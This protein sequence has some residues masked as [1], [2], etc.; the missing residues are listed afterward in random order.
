MLLLLKQ[1]SVGCVCLI[2]S[3][4]SQR[5][6]YMTIGLNVTSWHAVPSLPVAYVVVSYILAQTR[7]SHLF[8]VFGHAQSRTV[9]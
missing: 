8:D 5:F 1:Y 4:H 9:V 2:M 7:Y 3:R 6:T